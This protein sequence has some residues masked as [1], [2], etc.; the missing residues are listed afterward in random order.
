MKISEPLVPPNPNEFE[1]HYNLIN[2]YKSLNPEFIFAY[3]GYNFRSTEL[4][5][6]IGFC[7][8]LIEDASE[9]KQKGFVSDLNKIHKSG[10]D[11]LALINDILDLSSISSNRKLL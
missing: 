10:I 6:I 7:E 5:A 9:S 8:I 3:S 11:L 4:N 2:K 1:K